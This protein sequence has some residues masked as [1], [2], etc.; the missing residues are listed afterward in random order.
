[1]KNGEWHKTFHVQRN[2][3]NIRLRLKLI[4]GWLSAGSF[5]IYL[6]GL[7]LCWNLTPGKTSHHTAQP[8]ARPEG[9][10]ISQ[11]G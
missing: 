7:F 5:Y 6:L 3:I 11:P 8:A 10:F 4:C 1:M 9:I 2:A